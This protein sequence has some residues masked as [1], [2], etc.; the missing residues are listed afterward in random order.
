MINEKVTFRQNGWSRSYIKT[1][2]VLFDEREDRIVHNSAIMERLT[3]DG[4]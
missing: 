3:K 4:F 1:T 2:R